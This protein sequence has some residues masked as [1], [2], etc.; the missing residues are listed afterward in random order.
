MSNEETEPEPAS[1]P[2]EDLPVRDRRF[3]LWPSNGYEPTRDERGNI[4]T[5]GAVGQLPIEAAFLRAYAA[6]PD[7][8]RPIDLGVGQVIRGVVYR[9]SGVGVYDV[10]RVI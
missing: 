5:S 1:K 10:Y 3:I 4:T 9:L 7:A 6:Y 8:R 2:A